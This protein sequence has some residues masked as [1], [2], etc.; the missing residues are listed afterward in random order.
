[1]RIKVGSAHQRMSNQSAVLVVRSQP[2]GTGD[3]KYW[4][5][6]GPWTTLEPEVPA[7]LVPR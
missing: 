3:E 4:L 5:T 7:P 6:K 1:M 2:F